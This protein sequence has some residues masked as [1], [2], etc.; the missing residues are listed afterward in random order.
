MRSDRIREINAWLVRVALLEE[1]VASEELGGHLQ[2]GVRLILQIVDEDGESGWGEGSVTLSGD[3]IRE[4]LNRLAQKRLGE[5]RLTLLD[6]WPAPTYFHKPLPP[7]P[8]APCQAGMVHR[9]RHPLQAPVE[10]ALLDLFARRADL[11][12]HMLFGGAWRDRVSVDYWMGRTTPEH[13]VRCVNRGRAL[14]F[15][16][17]KLKTTLE[18][19]N[20]ERLEAIRD[21]CGE[22]WSVT[23]DPN[24]RFYNLEDSL[25]TILEMERVGN[26]AI[27]EDPFPQFHLHEYAGLRQRMKARLVMHVGS[28]EILDQ[29]I[30][31]RFFGGLNIDS[32][33]QG[34]MAWRFQAATAAQANLS[35]WHG[36]GLDLGI[37]TAAQLHLAAA[38]PNCRL[39]G[40]QSGPWLR[41]ASLVAT[42]FQ[43]ENGHVLVPKGPG[44]GVEVDVDALD[45][46]A[47]QSWKTA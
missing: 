13:A 44:L 30:H 27:L 34:L 3:V 42:S 39:P 32:H 45:K 10:M 20:V 9:L 19:P 7:S 26:M 14:G 25:S 17:V 31:S 8:F 1:W 21:A 18:D 2:G 11:P 40:D 16:G 41:E 37:A 4:V 15:T 33:V 23:V 36:S 29:V 5:L 28:P 35:I 6:L 38:T 24:G 43:V 22:E 46:F 47:V 12:L